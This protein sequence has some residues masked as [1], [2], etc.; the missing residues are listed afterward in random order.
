MKLTRAFVA[1]ALVLLPA[2]AGGPVPSGQTP[3]LVWVTLVRWP[4]T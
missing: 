3:S 1:L 2:L 4:F